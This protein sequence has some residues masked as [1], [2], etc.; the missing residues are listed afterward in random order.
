MKPI[1]LIVKPCAD[2]CNIKCGYC[3]H[4]WLKIS[5]VV[6]NKKIMDRKMVDIL[7]CNLESLPQKRIKIIWHGGEPLLIGKEFFYYVLE[8]QKN[9]PSKQ[10]INL[11]QTNGTLIDDDWVEIF[12]IGKFNVGVSIDGPKH[13]HDILRKD[14]HG[15]GTFDNVLSGIQL[16][17]SKNIEVGPI[18]VITKYN[19]KNSKEIFNFLCDKKLLKMNFSPCVEDGLAYSLTPIE[20]AKFLLDVYFIW[21]EKDDPAIK[22]TPLESFIH[23]LLGGKSTVCY[24]SK[25]CSRFISVDNEG[26]VYVCGRTLGIEDYKIGN[27]KQENINSIIVNEKSRV[28]NAKNSTLV[29][30][31]YSCR[32]LNVCNGGCPLHRGIGGADAGY[33]FCEAM[34]I[35]LPEI[36]KSIKRFLPSV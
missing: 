34:K 1:T 7:F 23:C 12:K 15:E 2:L 33:Y 17:Q 32:W 27:L 5:G 28:V 19:Y 11:I 26:S 3:Y 20:W 25:D 36:E 18:S 35:A 6:G 14:K 24:Y 21:M 22:I 13:L 29:D 31:C 8:K 10:F 9:C 30:N 4:N 16:I